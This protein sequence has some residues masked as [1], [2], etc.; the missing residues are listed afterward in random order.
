MTPTNPRPG[1]IAQVSGLS[2]VL[3]AQPG[4][5]RCQREAE[6]SPGNPEE[7][8]D[9]VS[10]T[11]LTQEKP[12]PAE[13]KGLG[14]QDPVLSPTELM[15]CPDG[16][17]PQQGSSPVT[18][19]LKLS[20]GHSE[21]RSRQGLQSRPETQYYPLQAPQ[22]QAAL[23]SVAPARLNSCRP[24]TFLPSSGPAGLKNTQN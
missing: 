12:R 15:T 19:T 2:G 18:C 1:L 7:A 11:Q 8:I 21:L 9:S 10:P 16:A 14:T 5:Y 3:A 13:D 17:P 23:R 6:E 20:I 22:P 24:G 4:C